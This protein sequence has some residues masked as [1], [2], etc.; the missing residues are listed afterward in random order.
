MV[1]TRDFSGSAIPSGKQQ[2]A[3]LI[4]PGR[5]LPCPLHWVG[6]TTT[7]GVALAETAAD[8]LDT[9][10]TFAEF[11]ESH[12]SSWQFYSKIRVQPKSCQI[13]KATRS[14]LS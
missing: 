9:K 13:G 8:K 14:N 3:I 6:T 7:S 2:A 5:T 10:A 11:M 4:Q 1:P 12:E